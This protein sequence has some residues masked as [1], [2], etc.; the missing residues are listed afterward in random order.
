M[1][2]GR[3][4]MDHEMMSEQLHAFLSLSFELFEYCLYLRSFRCRAAQLISANTNETEKSK[5]LQDAKEEWGIVCELEASAPTKVWLHQACLYVSWQSYRELMV[6]F[7]RSNWTMSSDIAAAVG[8]WYPAWT[9]SANI[10]SMFREMEC[11]LRK[12]GCGKDSLPNLGAVAIRALERRVCSGDEDCPRTIKLND[13]DWSCKMVRG[14][15]NRMFNPAA[16]S[17]CFSSEFF[18]Q[19]PILNS[20][21]KQ[22][23]AR[24]SEWMTS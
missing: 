18:L 20:G 3:S 6:T 24:I 1:C 12:S 7:E 14:L 10:E 11:S 2:F 9:Q 15:K 23:K 22:S 21:C 19:K 8:A 16:F 4:D 5:I 17:P 13:S